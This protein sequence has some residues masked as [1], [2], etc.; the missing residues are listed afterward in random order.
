MKKVELKEKNNNLPVLLDDGTGG[1]HVPLFSL[2]IQFLA[3]VGIVGRDTTH[4]SALALSRLI[5]LG[6]LPEQLVPLIQDFMRS[7]TTPDGIIVIIVQI[8]ICILDNSVG[9][10]SDTTWE[11]VAGRWETFEPVATAC[12][13]RSHILV[14]ISNVCLEGNDIRTLRRA[15]GGGSIVHIRAREICCKDSIHCILNVAAVVDQHLL[16]SHRTVLWEHFHQL[17]HADVKLSLALP[18]CQGSIADLLSE[19]LLNTLHS[20]E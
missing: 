17:G 10:G 2:D 3:F 15:I 8:R 4:S 6:S 1:A 16:Q 9:E 7:L 19:S 20:F 18:S 12:G 11:W 14:R 13:V 5:S